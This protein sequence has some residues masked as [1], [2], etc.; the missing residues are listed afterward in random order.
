M[1]P[2]L[3]LSILIVAHN[4]EDRVVRTVESAL[5]RAGD[6]TLE[7]LVVDNGSTDRTLAALERMRGP[8]RLLR[9]ANTGFAAGNNLALPQA[10]G[11]YVLLLNP[12][13][14]LVSGDL[15][16]FVAALDRRPEV[17][18]A[19][20]VQRSPSGGLLHTINRFPSPL[21]D[22]GEALFV[23]HSPLGKNLQQA[24]TDPG[25][26][27]RERSADWL[28][29]SFLLLRRAA[30]EQVG[31]LDERFFLY[32]EETD[33]CLRLKNAGW[34]VRHLPLMAVVHHEGGY[35]RPA[36]AAQLS[37]SKVLF[38]EKHLGRAG[39]AAT[40]LS[41]AVRHGLRVLLSV[42]PALGRRR[43]HSRLACEWHALTVVLR[44]AP[45]PF[46]HRSAGA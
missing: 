8:V 6:L 12:D 21:R 5:R 31:R 26:Y 11:R 39:T 43:S 45:P 22:L 23:H 9:N 14:D 13:V 18:A 10:R 35:E 32:S 19:G 25:E 30:L 29:G 40:R 37:H 17:G 15:S 44:L 3:D 16:D 34:D 28:V 4:G 7:V 24:V 1:P 27:A 41:L 42:A 38:A 33:L 2:A 20:V 36:L 46:G